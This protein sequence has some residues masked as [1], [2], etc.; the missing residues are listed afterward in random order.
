MRIHL[1]YFRCLHSVKSVFPRPINVTLSRIDGDLCAEANFNP[2]FFELFES[3]LRVL[4]DFLHR[5]LEGTPK[6]DVKKSLTVLTMQTKCLQ[7]MA[8]YLGYGDD[9]SRASHLDVVLTMLHKIENNMKHGRNITYDAKYLRSVSTNVDNFFTK[10]FESKFK[11]IFVI[12][13]RSQWN[14]GLQARGLRFR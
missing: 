5:L 7:S 14:K 3:F 12:F 9:I 8:K 11:W 6:T 13:L 4:L 1:K 2:E 10:Q